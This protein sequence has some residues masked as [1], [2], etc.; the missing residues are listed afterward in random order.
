MNRIEQEFRRQLSKTEGAEGAVDM[1]EHMETLR[2]LASECEHVTEFG[3]RYVV[4]TWAF[5]YG[6]PGTVVSYD[7]AYIAEMK[8]AEEICRTAGRQWT[9]I[10]ADVNK[11]EIEPTDLLF[12]DTVHTY[13]QLSRE[14]RM[15]ADKAR[16]YIALHDTVHF[17]EEGEDH[18]RPGLWQ[19]VQELIGQGQWEIKEH[20]PYCNGL[21]VLERADTEREPNENP[22]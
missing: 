19:A 10:Q 6:C 13:T 9:L 17:G 3:V 16:K 22:H 21:T 5:L 15:H 1:W 18:K 4:S 14:F 7:C 20:Y 2:R 11:I 12:I 8:R